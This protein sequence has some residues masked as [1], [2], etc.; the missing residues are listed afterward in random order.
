MAALCM[1][2][3]S[4]DERKGVGYW[5]EQE[6]GEGG[7]MMRRKRE[8]LQGGGREEEGRVEKREGEGGLGTGIEGESDGSKQEGPGAQFEQFAPAVLSFLSHLFFAKHST[9]NVIS[10]WYSSFICFICVL[11]YRIMVHRLSSCT[12]AIIRPVCSCCPFFPLS[13]SKYSTI[14]VLCLYYSF[15]LCVLNQRIILYSP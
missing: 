5:N 9:I 12:H 4:S 15:Y 1:G 13:S 7:V 11:K 14:N 10:L 6:E 8:D 3:S 2:G